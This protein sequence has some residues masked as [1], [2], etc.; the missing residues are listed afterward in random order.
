VWNGT[1][2]VA[3][4]NILPTSERSNGSDVN[5]YYKLEQ[6]LA[7][8]DG[9]YSLIIGEF[10]HEHSYVDQVQ[11]LA[12]DHDSDVKIAVDPNGQILT[13]KNPD[14]PRTAV[15]NYGNSRLNEIRSIN[16]NV[17]NPATYFYGNAS[18]YLVLNFGRVNSDNAKLI[19]RDDQKC[20][21]CCIDVQVLNSAGQW[22]TVT[23]VAPRSYWAFEGVDLSA[24]V[25]RNRDFKVRLVWASPHKL[26]YAGLDTTRQAEYQITYANLISATHSTQG[27]VTSLLTINDDQYAELV[28]GQLILLDF[29][30]PDNQQEART[31]ILYTEGHYI[32]IP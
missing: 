11:L 13:Y 4:N 31:Y 32:T 30:L 7:Q 2:L 12:V 1:A 21:D 20:D 3:D 22:H 23:T 8:S 18:D 19:L 9:K 25:V 28:P 5:D 24:Y 16:G 10:E 14:A 29:T 17:S 26:D 15:D 27:D 6:T